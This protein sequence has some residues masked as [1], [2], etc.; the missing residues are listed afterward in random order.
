MGVFH[1]SG[2]PVVGDWGGAGHAELG[3]YLNGM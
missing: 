1:L 3:V 2:T